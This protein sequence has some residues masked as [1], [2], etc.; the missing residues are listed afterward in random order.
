[1]S[2]RQIPDAVGLPLTRVVQVVGAL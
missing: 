1:M 2:Y